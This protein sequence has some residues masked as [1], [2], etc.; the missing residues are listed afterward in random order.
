MK[1]RLLVEFDTEAKRWS[2]V[3]PEVP[4]CGSAGD[5]EEEAVQNAREA[6]ALWFAPTELDLPK[7][8]KLVEVTVP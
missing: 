5:T 3:F 6:L 2:A 8:A 1:F 4:G 7:E